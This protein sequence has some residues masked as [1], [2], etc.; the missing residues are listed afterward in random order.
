MSAF[1]VIAFDAD[2]TLWHSEILYQTAQARIVK[3]LLPFGEESEIMARLN[4]IEIGN[5][6]IYGYG[7]K[8]FAISMIE[9]AIELSDGQMSGQEIREIISCAKEMLA[10]D[11]QLLQHVTEV[12]A[13]L[14]MQSPLMII[15]KGD[16]FEQEAKI[17]RSGLGPYFQHV[18][19]VSQKTRDSYQRVLERYHIPPNR[20]L[21]V[22]NSLRSDVLPVLEL[23]GFAAYIPSSITWDHEVVENPS[24]GHPRFFQLENVRQLP[25][26]LNSIE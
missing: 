22:G 20:F 5:L 24:T 10:A 13:T 3:Q 9:A 2:D 26:L 18:E 11:I 21:M 17:S 6:N 14:R 8:G 7:V 23:G 4:E 1:D 16:L 12:F 15:T 25:A 19:V